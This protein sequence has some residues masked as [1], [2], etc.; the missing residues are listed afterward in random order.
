MFT[1]QAEN[2]CW[3]DTEQ[4]REVFTHAES[5]IPKHRDQLR[6][7]CLI[8]TFKVKKMTSCSLFIKNNTTACVKTVTYT[9][10]D[11]AGCT[12]REERMNVYEFP[13]AEN[14]EKQRVI[15]CV[16]AGDAEIM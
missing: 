15:T 9:I 2:H 13:R 1:V 10:P 5:N 12:E 16:T 7:N 8:E 11:H 14:K 4:E 3:M 6:K